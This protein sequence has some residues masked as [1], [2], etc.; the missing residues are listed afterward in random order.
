MPGLQ[1][2]GQMPRKE[3]PL[4]KVMGGGTTG[5]IAGMKEGKTEKLELEKVDY[6]KKRDTAN[7]IISV[8]KTLRPGQADDFINK[9]EVKAL[10]D[11]LKWPLPTNLHKK[12]DFK[13]A[14]QEY[15][16][17]GEPLPGMTMDET[18]KKAGVYIA[19]DKPLKITSADIKGTPWSFGDIVPWVES[20]KEKM[21][22]MRKEQF[23]GRAYSGGKGVDPLGARR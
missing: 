7:M 18:K 23:A 16:M 12:V 15:V 17:K 19:P 22:R 10:F 14:A 13:E 8:A 6:G 2:L 1:W 20:P 9:P 11:N 21:E 3:S 4:A 5:Y